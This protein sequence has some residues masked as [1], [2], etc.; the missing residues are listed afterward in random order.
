M[1]LEN[2]EVLGESWRSCGRK[3]GEYDQETLK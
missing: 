3:G 2:G 1:K